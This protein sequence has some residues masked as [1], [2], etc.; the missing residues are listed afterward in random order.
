MPRLERRKLRRIRFFKRIKELVRLNIQTTLTKISER[1]KQRLNLRKSINDRIKSVEDK[2]K[3]KNVYLTSEKRREAVREI[4]LYSK[5]CLYNFSFNNAVFENY[6]INTYGLSSVYNKI[7]ELSKY[8]GNSLSG[9]PAYADSLTKEL[10]RSY[11]TPLNSTLFHATFN[12]IRLT[13]LTINALYNKPSDFYVMYNVTV[14]DLTNPYLRSSPNRNLS[15]FWT[16]LMY[17]KGKRERMRNKSKGHFGIVK[18]DEPVHTVINYNR[19]PMFYLPLYSLIGNTYVLARDK[20]FSLGRPELANKLNAIG[21]FVIPYRKSK[22]SK[23]ES[24]IKDDTISYH[25]RFKFIRY[26]H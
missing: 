7:L 11:Y 4:T 14:G 13:D 18:Y 22:L 9:I 16:K 25:Y 6:L 10:A 1:I 3:R 23:K 24:I 2:I 26:T 8:A 5:A 15:E 21:I 20:A 19:V 17:K 12:A